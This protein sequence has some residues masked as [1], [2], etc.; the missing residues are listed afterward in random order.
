MR[1]RRI[2]RGN[3]W[4]IHWEL[5]GSPA[6]MRPRRIRR[7]NQGGRGH[8]SSGHKSFNE[9]AA[10]SPR[11]RR[12]QPCLGSLPG[13]ASMRPRRIRRGNCRPAARS[14]TVVL[15]SMRPRRI[16]RGNPTNSRW[17]RSAPSRFNEAA[18]NSPRKPGIQRFVAGADLVASMR[19]RRIRRGN[20]TNSRWPRSAP[21]RFNEAAANSPRKLP[22]NSTMIVVFLG[23]NEAAANSPRKHQAP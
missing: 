16:R 19:P 22:H 13:S 8:E 23:F 15:A 14:R 3:S 20:P 4:S 9:A 10:N 17:P 5:P 18:A 2:R 11:K 21:S 12:T 1:P 6:S 7:G